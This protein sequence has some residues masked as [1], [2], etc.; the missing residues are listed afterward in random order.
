MFSRDA[1]WP[2]TLRIFCVWGERGA[3]RRNRL[4]SHDHTSTL[5][6][7]PSQTSQSTAEPTS[8]RCQRQ[9]RWFSSKGVRPRREAPPGGW[10]VFGHWSGPEAGS[11]WDTALG[12]RPLQELPRPGSPHRVTSLSAVARVPVRVK[13]FDLDGIWGD[14]SHQREGNGAKRTWVASPWSLSLSC[15]PPTRPRGATPW[16]R[17]RAARIW[18]GCSCWWRWR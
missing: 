9:E 5:P 4:L 6:L 14:L 8:E 13:S 16:W 18:S 15:L 3:H 12:H 2:P 7:S 1:V 10:G 11:G 17:R